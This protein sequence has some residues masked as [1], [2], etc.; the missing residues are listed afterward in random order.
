MIAPIRTARVDLAQHHE[1]AEFLNMLVPI[2]RRASR[3]ARYHRAEAREDFVQA[4]VANAYAAWF[5]LV[6][7]GRAERAFPTPLA[8]YAIRQVRAGR[9]VGCRQNTKDV[10]SG[11]SAPLAGRLIQRLG[12]PDRD[13]RVYNQLLVEDRR[14]G[15]AETAAARLDIRA[16]F[17]ALSPRTRQI[18]RALALGESTSAVARQFG[19][20]AGRISQCRNWLRRNWEEFHKGTSNYS[21][22]TV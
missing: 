1:P 10:L 3:A 21:G 4:V 14:A 7:E 8:R 11:G 22:V 9:R 16:W 17:S 12:Q 6:A 13:R 15:P 19:L 20:S 2:Q 18:A 5:R